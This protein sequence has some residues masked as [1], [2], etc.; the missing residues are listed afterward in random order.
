MKRFKKGFQQSLP[1]EIVTSFTTDTPKE[2]FG[3]TSIL[4][5]WKKCSRGF[6][7]TMFFQ[8]YEDL[9]GRLE[10]VIMELERQ[11]NVLVVCH[12]AVMRCLLAYF[13]EKSPGMVTFQPMFSVKKKYDQKEVEQSR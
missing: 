5:G 11:E 8:S 4:K 7:S 13:M 2:R 1:L 10:P 6:N 9:V 3:T 12:Q